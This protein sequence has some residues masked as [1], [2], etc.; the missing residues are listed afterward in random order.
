MKRKTSKNRHATKKTAKSAAQLD[1]E[2]AEVLSQKRKLPAAWTKA[3]KHELFYLSDLSEDQQGGKHAAHIERFD[4]LRDAIDMLA[5]LPEGSI[6]YG[7]AHQGPKFMIVWAAPAHS[8]LLYWTDGDLNVADE[9]RKE[10]RTIKK[11]QTKRYGDL[12]Q[13]FRQALKK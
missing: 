5:R 11:K 13:R 10:A 12:D 7:N 1:R 6:T 8:E 3:L 2:I 9:T 4:N